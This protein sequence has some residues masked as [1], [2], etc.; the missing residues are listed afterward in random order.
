MGTSLDPVSM[1]SNTRAFLKDKEIVKKCDDFPR[2]NSNDNSESKY[3]TTETISSILESPDSLKSSLKSIHFNI[4]GI[5]SN[6]TNFL[7]FLKS[8]PFQF[9]V[10]SLSETHLPRSKIYLNNDKFNLEGYSIHRAFST[11]SYGGCIIYV[12]QPLQSHTIAEL[13]G[14]DSVCDHLYVS[15]T[16]PDDP[17]STAIIGTYYRHNKRNKASITQ[18]TDLVDDHLSS[19]TL[20]KKHLIL[21]G[22]MN[23]D[24]CKTDVDCDIEI[25][26][27]TF[28][29]HNLESH[30]NKPTRIQY[31]PNSLMVHSATIIDHVFSNMYEYPCA[32]GNLLYPDSDHYAT[33]LSVSNFFAKK[34]FKNPSSEPLL[35][36]N[37]S[38]ISVE[39]LHRDFNDLDWAS[40][41]YDP[42][43]DI[44]SATSNLID[45]ITMLC[46]KHAPMKPVPRR[47][48]VYIHKP[49]ISSEIL[50]LIIRKNKLAEKKA[51]KSTEENVNAFR[52]MRNLVNSKLNKAKNEY[53]RNY[54]NEHKRN[55][56]KV[57]KG[58]RCALEWHKMKNSS[59][60]SVTDTEG[61]LLTDSSKI[62]QS[63]A[64]YFKH[65]PAKTVRKIPKGLGRPSFHSYLS[66]THCHSMALF[67]TTPVEMINLLNGLKSN[68]S[69]GP[70]SFSN[71]FIKLLSPILAPILAHLVNRSFS[72]SIMPDCLK[73]GKQTPVFKG[74]A[75]IISNYRPITVCNSIAKIFEKV[76]RTR[77]MGFLSRYKIL[78][79]NQFG[80]RQFHSTNHAMIKVLDETLLGLDDSD[81]KTGTIFLDISKAFDCVNYPILFHKLNHYG[82]RGVVLNWFK[83]FLHNRSQYVEVNGEKSH[84]YSP[85]LGIPQGSV[86]GP[87]LFLL[88][89]NDVSSASTKFSFSIFADDTSLLLKVDRNDYDNTLSAELTKVM[90]WF[91]SNQ[92]L[93]NHEKTQYMFFGPHHPKQ[94]ERGDFVLKDLYESVPS[95]LLLSD[96]YCNLEE[97]MSDPSIK[98]VY[99]KGEFVLAE[100]H[101]AVPYYLLT[102]HIETDYGILV[103]QE[104]VRY[105]G[106]VFDDHLTFS[107]HI[108]NIA[109]KISQVVGNLWKARWLPRD[110]K[111]SVYNSLVASQI[112]FA[113]LIWGSD[114]AGNITRGITSLDHVPKKLKALN[115]AHNNAVRAIVC[116]TRE[117]PLTPIFRVLNLLKLVDVYYLNLGIFAYSSLT[118]RCPDFFKDYLTNGSVPAPHCTR[119]N[120]SSSNSTIFY[121]L[122]KRQKTL[123]S[124]LIASKALWNKIPDSVK[125]SPSLG[126]FKIALKKWLMKDYKSSRENDSN[127]DW[128]DINRDIWL[129]ISLQ[130][131][132]KKDTSL[133]KEDTLRFP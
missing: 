124:V 98:R 78:S 9:D 100:L 81:F 102:E 52:G 53:F 106:V 6:F 96:N 63:F 27:N 82:I 40:T 19:K 13:T 61:N 128:D 59:I 74:G 99:E 73:I 127:N 24:L 69:P 80:F 93:L 28:F 42:S 108:S 25:Y 119:S 67:D 118:D 97:Q 44:H 77:L 57:W 105:L 85:K 47:K 7:L 10:I 103:Q 39:D 86:L 48:V 8:L 35:K 120:S 66:G 60:N 30:I 38:K 58:I 104:E 111:L 125:C 116:S 54:F 83:S 101:E 36:R 130:D 117:Q 15:V 49:W 92:L 132:Q 91:F 113:I 87:I 75:N 126:T 37:L 16:N 2:L 23:I 41:V 64:D 11:I 32:S 123:N 62:S 14:S 71:N 34:S 90:D 4:R 133:K 29:K 84:P 68:S 55:S 112:N 122:P 70:L 72:E 1:H 110:I 76:V 51:K 129:E 18:F 3:F 5:E 43:L 88:Y 22:D 114:F 107:R 56:R 20:R 21:N 79:R 94:Y 17:K 46:D 31:K 109:S 33:V 50:S 131:M 12:R 65:I 26:V 95:Y 115:T 45:N 121:S 89:T